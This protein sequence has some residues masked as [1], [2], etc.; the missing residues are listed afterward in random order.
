[1]CA[2]VSVSQLE[3]NIGGQGVDWADGPLVERMLD[4]MVKDAFEN[5]HATTRLEVRR[6]GVVRICLLALL[7]MCTMQPAVRCNLQY[8]PQPCMY[9]NRVQDARSCSVCFAKVFR[10]VQLVPA[11]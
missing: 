9:V 8:I 6:T 5:F 3:G 10:F 1:M 4:W 11:C 7:V 2:C